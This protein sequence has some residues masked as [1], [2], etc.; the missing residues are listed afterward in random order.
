MIQPRFNLRDPNSNSTL[1]NLILS[2]DGKRFKVSTGLSVP[3][4]YWNLKTDRVKEN[5]EFNDYNKI[6]SK[7]EELQSSIRSAYK[8]FSDQEI[9]PSVDSLKAKY[10][11]L[12][13][14]PKKMN[15]T[16]TAWDYFDEFVE[17]QRGKIHPRSVLD[18]D[19]ALRKHLLETE[20][21]FNLKLSFNA[22]RSSGNFVE[23]LD[24]Y[25]TKYAI[26]ADGEKGFSL[27][28]K[29]KQ[30]KNVKSFL[31]WCFMKEYCP[32]FSIKHIVKTSEEV[33]NIYLNQDEL[34]LIY[35]LKLNDKE[36]E[37]TRDLFIVGCETGLRYSDFSRLKS[38]HIGD[39]YINI[40][41]T[42]V[43]AKVVIPISNRLRLLIQKYD[44]NL[45]QK[46]S[47]D[48]TGF[49]EQVRQVGEIA[50][51][52]ETIVIKQTRGTEMK[53]KFFKKHE[54]MSS[55]TCRRSFC[56]NKF[57]KGVPVKVIMSISGHKTEK[58]FMKYLKLSN[59]EIIKAYSKQLTE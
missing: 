13:I 38:E 15:S 19:K 3:P 14:N 5:K 32:M 11:E 31:N 28:G 18:Y 54:L 24:L 25:L 17:Y 30:M 45:P 35:N 47:K 56:T 50:C 39:D 34:D 44:G 49:N 51:L 42:K 29:G 20:K 1:I 48:L 36:L 58:A 59:E 12:L 22:L 27:N 4:K 21:R 43:K 26:N 16:K 8:F 41:Q 10:N 52:N 7:L 46:T 9:V 57:L 2:Y 33:D 53:E 40:F 55:H 37:T 6:N 23:K